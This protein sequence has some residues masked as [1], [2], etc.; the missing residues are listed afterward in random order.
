MSAKKQGGKAPE[1]LF[2]MVAKNRDKYPMFDQLLKIKEAQKTAID[3]QVKVIDH[4]KTVFNAN[5]AKNLEAV[6]YVPIKFKSLQDL[7]NNVEA[8]N[9]AIETN[10]A[11][12]SGLVNSNF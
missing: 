12:I 3:S 6:K 11:I 1:S 9:R 7:V 5:G 10:Q 4:L 8:N 2:E